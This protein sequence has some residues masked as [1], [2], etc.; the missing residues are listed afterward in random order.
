MKQRGIHD[1][2]LIK[3]T[4]SSEVAGSLRGEVNAGAGG[5]GGPGQPPGGHCEGLSTAMGLGAQPLVFGVS[6]STSVCQMPLGTLSFQS[7]HQG[8]SV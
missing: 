1:G 3:G 6:P 5:G 7:H 4:G 8:E 2:R